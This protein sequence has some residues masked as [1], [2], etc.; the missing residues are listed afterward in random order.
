MILYLDASALVKRY[1]AEAG[2]AEISAAGSLAAVTGTVLVSRA[3]VAAAL[4]KAVRVNALTREGALAALQVFRNDWGDLVRIQVTE[5]V[6]ARADALAWDH[7]L[8]GYDALQLAAAL[9]WQDALGEQVTLATFDKYLW[10]VAGSVGLAPYPTDLPAMLQ[11][12]KTA[13]QSP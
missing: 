12:W 6:V 4:A 11:S 10:T 8:R 9:V 5:M 2:S 7:N 1:V 13:R 3:E